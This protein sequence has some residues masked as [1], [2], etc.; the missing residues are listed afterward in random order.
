MFGGLNRS[1][2]ALLR[3]VLVLMIMVLSERRACGFSLQPLHASKLGSLSRVTRS[4]NTLSGSQPCHVNQQTAANQHSTA[5]RHYRLSTLFA[6]QS[7]DNLVS[8]QR[9]ILESGRWNTTILSQ[10]PLVFVVPGFLSPDECQAY[11]DYVRDLPDRTMTRSN[12]PQVSLQVE[13]LWPLSILSIVGGL[14]SAVFATMREIDTGNDSSSTTITQILSHI[15]FWQTAIVNTGIALFASALLAFAL[16]LPVV[17]LW[18]TSAS[19]TSRAVALNQH[20]TDTPVIYNLMTRLQILTSHAWSHWEAP[21]VTCYEPGA[22]FATHADASPTGGSEWLQFGGQRLVTCIVYLNSLPQGGAT[23]FNALDIAVQ[24][25][26]G[27]A[28]VFFPANSETWEADPRTI[29]ESKATLLQGD[30]S[31]DTTNKWIVQ[32]FGRA[33]RVPA[34]LGIADGAFDDSVDLISVADVVKATTTTTSLP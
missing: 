1:L 8:R 23:L 31:D 18:A 12:P 34:P 10:D 22:R 30:T 32:V 29:H 27:T 28:L 5:R 11:I 33:M 7:T 9:T 2:T 20:P 3:L 16:V 14:V 6:T 26:Q 25:T 24:P 21:V 4:Y 17:K 15:S 19:R 13:R